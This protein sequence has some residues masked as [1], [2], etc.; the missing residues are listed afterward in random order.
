RAGEQGRGFAV[1]AAEVRTLS[2]RTSASAREIKALISQSTDRV[3]SGSA[4]AGEAGRTM[5]H[6]VTA[7]QRVTGLMD[8]IHRG[9]AEQS[10]GIS[11][12]NQAV[13]EMEQVTQQNAALVEEA[14]AA[15]E[16]LKTQAAQ[17]ER[18]VGAFRLDESA[19]EAV[20]G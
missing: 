18:T 10:G 16:A 14:A 11:Q 17:M 4:Q 8:E 9:S 5:E 13:L 3:E 20:M 7:V 2:Q 12:V 1:V 6:I 15:A 19:D